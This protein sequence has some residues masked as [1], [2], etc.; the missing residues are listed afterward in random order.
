[1]EQSLS[2]KSTNRI[3]SDSKLKFIADFLYSNQIT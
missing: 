2:F 3:I 1:M